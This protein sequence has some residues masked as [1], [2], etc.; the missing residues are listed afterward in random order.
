MKQSSCL[1]TI[2][3]ETREAVLSTWVIECAWAYKDAAV[4]LGMAAEYKRV[5]EAMQGYVSTEILRPSYMALAQR[6]IDEVDDGRQSD[7]YEEDPVGRL[8]QAWVRFALGHFRKA[9]GPQ[10]RRWVLQATIG[11]GNGVGRS[12]A[13]NLLLGYILDSPLDGAVT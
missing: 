13:A 9:G 4:M 10:A 3:E 6:Y 1:D 11:L 2:V 5:V 7:L 12:S 8:R